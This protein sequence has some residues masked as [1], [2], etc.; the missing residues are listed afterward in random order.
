MILP[1]HDYYRQISAFSDF[2]SPKEI[3][4]HRDYNKESTQLP[5]SSPLVQQPNMFSFSI[6]LTALFAASYASAE[7]VE[8]VAS[9]VVILTEGNFE[10]ET[11]VSTGATTGDWLIEFY[12]P[13]FLRIILYFIH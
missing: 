5:D 1:D 13:W 11:Q 9:D 4:T 8:A 12:A 2:P 3:S 10:L 6:V 7:S